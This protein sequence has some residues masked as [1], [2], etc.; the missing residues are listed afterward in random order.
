MGRPLSFDENAVR[1]A[2]RLRTKVQQG[3]IF[4]MWLLGVELTLLHLAGIGLRN[5]N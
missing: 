5:N 1:N 2:S 4:I 3:Y